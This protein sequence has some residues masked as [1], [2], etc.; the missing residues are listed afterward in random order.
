MIVHDSK[1]QQD[2]EY[3]KTS[4]DYF[5]IWSL[6]KINMGL[7]EGMLKIFRPSVL[8]ISIDI[9]SSCLPVR[10]SLLVTFHIVI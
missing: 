10:V 4:S 2:I 5:N 1:T 7:K 3:K 9:D 8:L 6:S